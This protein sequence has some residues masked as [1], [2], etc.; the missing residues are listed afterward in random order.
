MLSFRHAGC[1]FG[2]TSCVRIGGGEETR[3]RSHAPRIRG[4]RA[5]AVCADPAER[6][7]E[8]LLWWLLPLLLSLTS[9][10]ASRPLQPPSYPFF[11][12]RLVRLVR[13]QLGNSTRTPAE[14]CL[15]PLRCALRAARSG[16]SPGCFFLLF[17]SLV[18]SFSSSS[19]SSSS[20]RFFFC[21][22]F[23][24][25]SF[26]SSSLAPTSRRMLNALFSTSRDKRDSALRGELCRK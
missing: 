9:A 6:Y 11:L 3:T 21:S 24:P 13:R 14:I 25:S 17:L 2:P 20:S 15:S 12:V 7:T 1:L 5:F 23:S 8:Q 4:V 16:K 26:F 18:V 19:S 10:I 22:F